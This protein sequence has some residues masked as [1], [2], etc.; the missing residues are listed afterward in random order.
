MM[1]QHQANTFIVRHARDAAENGFSD[2]TGS[3]TAMDRDNVIFVIGAPRSG[4]TWLHLLLGSHPEIATGQ[5]SQ[6]FPEYLA[7]LYARWQRELNYSRSE[8]VRQH[9]I[10]PYLSEEEF[11]D[12]LRH[13]ALTVFQK[14]MDEKPGA[15]YFLE[16]SPTSTVHIE[17]IARCFPEAR[18]IHIIRDGRDVATSLMMASRGWGRGWAP[19]KVEDAAGTWKESTLLAR[20][21][22]TLA[23]HYTEVRYEDLMEKGVE[24]LSRLFAFLGLSATEE[25]VANIYDSCRFEKLRSERG[26]Q[27]VFKNPGEIAASGTAGRREPP[28]FFRKGRVGDWVNELRPSDVAAF[29]WVAGDLLVELGY[30]SASEAKLPSFP[31]V[32]VTSRSALRSARKSLARLVKRVAGIPASQ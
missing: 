15:H 21:A 20:K 32:A 14:V 23:C 10:A 31:P 30:A 17:L 4:S 22:A 2:A 1:R 27:Q 13:F 25:D 16:K 12:L 7:P 29:N 11:I 6:V 9:G 26:S 24:E 3:R 8:E 28:D 19:R 18:Y 5:E